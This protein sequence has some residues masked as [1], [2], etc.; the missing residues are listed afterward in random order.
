[1]V[2]TASDTGK[3]RVKTDEELRKLNDYELLEEYLRNDE[4]E[5]PNWGNRSDKVLIAEM[6]R[7]LLERKADK[8]E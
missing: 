3:R 4:R 7:R 6:F 5:A 1:M 2:E 8:L